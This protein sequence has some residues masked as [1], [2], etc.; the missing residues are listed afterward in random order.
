MPSARNII[1][2]VRVL[3]CVRYQQRS[4]DVLY[5]KRR[6]TGRQIRIG[7]GA[8]ERCRCKSVV[9]NVDRAGMKV[10]GVEKIADPIVANGNTF[11][12]A[13]RSR[14]FR[15]RT[16]PGPGVPTCDSAV[17]GCKNKSGRRSTDLEIARDV[18]DHSS[19]RT[20]WWRT[21]CRRYSHDHREGY[22]VA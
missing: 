6:V 15:N 2:L 17:F 3:Q 7:K 22:A 5:I 19:W 12:N 10:G 4:I 14:S 21:R 8:S 16:R 18:K 9:K 13:I 11:V 1:L 20:G